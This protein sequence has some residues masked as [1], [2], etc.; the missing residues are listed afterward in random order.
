MCVYK[1]VLYLPYQTT[2]TMTTT[3]LFNQIESI[4][5]DSNFIALSAE[6]AKKLG[7]PAEEWNKNKM[8][9]LIMFAQEMLNRDNA[10]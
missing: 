7:I 2:T 3:N 9:Y 6:T 4:V 8:L 10:Q 5:T 1:F